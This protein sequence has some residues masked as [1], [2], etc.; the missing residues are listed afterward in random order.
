MELIL[1]SSPDSGRAAMAAAFFNA[2]VIPSLACSIAAVPDPHLPIQPLVRRAFELLPT[3]R[4]LLPPT[5]LT[6]EFGSCAG[7]IVHIGATPG[8]SPARDER[9]VDWEIP[10]PTGEPIE[11]VVAIRD[12]IH[13]RVQALLQTRQWLR[14]GP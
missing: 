10:D 7:Q 12:A 5:R 9:E 11:G 6:D 2:L 8:S 3:G 4:P 1:V 14:P 13:A